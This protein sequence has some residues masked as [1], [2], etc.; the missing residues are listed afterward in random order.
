MFRT[1]L[2]VIEGGRVTIPAKIRNQL[3]LEDGDPVIVTFESAKG[4]P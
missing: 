1:P 3:H 4:E 2:R